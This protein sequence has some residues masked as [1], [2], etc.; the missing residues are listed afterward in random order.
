[1][2][3]RYLLYLLRW[4]MSTPIL[5]LFVYWFTKSLGATW[6]TVLANLVGGLIFF[7]VDLWIFRS[8]NILFT[9]ELWEVKE[10]TVCAD[11]GEK[12]RSY[13]LIK[14]GAYDRTRDRQ[15]QFRCHICSRKKYAIM[16]PALASGANAATAGSTDA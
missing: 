6:T 14:A 1:M 9:G 3:R 12:G 13:R 15:P 10:D 8:T 5:A 4:Q 2:T 16:R 11:C 7:W